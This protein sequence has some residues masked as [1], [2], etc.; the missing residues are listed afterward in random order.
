MN[1]AGSLS[2]T[3]QPTL[4]REGRFLKFPGNPEDG[5]SEPSIPA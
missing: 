3:R 1:A 5:L 2:L 4:D